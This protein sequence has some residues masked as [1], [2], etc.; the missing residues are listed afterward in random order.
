VVVAVLG[1]AFLYYAYKIYLN[2]TKKP[3]GN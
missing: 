2:L 3:A 1:L